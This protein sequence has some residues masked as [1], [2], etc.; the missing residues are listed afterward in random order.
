MGP[1]EKARILVVARSAS[2]GNYAD[3]LDRAGHETVA[4]TSL[5]LAAALMRNIQFDVLVADTAGWLPRALAF[6]T[7]CGTLHPEQGYAPVRIVVAEN[8]AARIASLTCGA[9]TLLNRHQAQDLPDIL[10]RIVAAGR[11]IAASPDERGPRTPSSA[12]GGR[13]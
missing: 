13:P 1:G 3:A 4:V 8:D 11:G 9:D 10:E 12:H 5:R 7:H 6:V 2:A